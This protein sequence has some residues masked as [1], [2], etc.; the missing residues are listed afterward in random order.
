MTSGVDFARWSSGLGVTEAPS[1]DSCRLKTPALLEG[2]LV[3]AP[4]KRL[5]FKPGMLARCRLNGLPMDVRQTVLCE[6]E[7]FLE[8]TKKKPSIGSVDV[9]SFDVRV[10]P[11]R[12]GYEFGVLESF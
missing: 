11:E 10:R 9:Q 12:H 3:A 6:V 4:P 5:V 7:S 8:G 2:S 1:G